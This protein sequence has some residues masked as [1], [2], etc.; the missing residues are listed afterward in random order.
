VHPAEAQ[1]SAD[2]RKASYADAESNTTDKPRVSATDIAL[3][4]FDAHLLRLIRQTKGRD[5]K[6]FAKTAV[7]FVEILQ[8]ANFLLRLV[9][10]AGNEQAAVSAEAAE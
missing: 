3:I 6:R 9:P 8:L 2:A 4:E 1:A 10:N 7:P 5:A